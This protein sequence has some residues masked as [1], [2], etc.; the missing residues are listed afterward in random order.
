M[1][2]MNGLVALKKL[3][4]PRRIR[5]LLLVIAMGCAAKN[6][7]TEDQSKEQ[8]MKP[9]ENEWIVLFDG[10]SMDQWHGY[11]TEEMPPEWSMENKVL[12]FSPGKDGG[13]NIVT[14]ESFTN[15]VLSLEWKISE[16]GNSGIFWGVKRRLKLQ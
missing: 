12:K 9:T 6:E 2:T 4:L 15:F 13:K 11:N 5:L 14:N 10:S 3:P 16:G 8:E 7:K 1:K